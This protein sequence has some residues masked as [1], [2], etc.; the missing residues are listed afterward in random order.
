ME[1]NSLG[2]QMRKFDTVDMFC[3]DNEENVCA[4]EFHKARVNTARELSCMNYYVARIWKYLLL[5]LI[6]KTSRHC[7]FGTIHLTF[8]FRY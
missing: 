2:Q 7:Q 4:A 6:Q 8:E 1:S 3:T 5:N